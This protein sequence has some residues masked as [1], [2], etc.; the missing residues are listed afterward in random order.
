MFYWDFIVTTEGE[1]KKL[2]NNSF[3]LL[4]III[5]IHTHI[6]KEQLSS[7]HFRLLF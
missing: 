7:Y 6:R 2:K 4:L 3:S 5:N 1:K